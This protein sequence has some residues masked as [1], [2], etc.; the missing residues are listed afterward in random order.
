MK[1]A[2][3]RRPKIAFSL[4]CVECKPNTNAYETLVTVQGG[5]AQEE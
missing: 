3:L 2:K 5:H 4:S 1:I